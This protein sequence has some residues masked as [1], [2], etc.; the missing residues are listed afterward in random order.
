MKDHIADIKQNIFPPEWD[1]DILDKYWQV[2]DCKHITAEFVPYGYPV[3]SITEVQSSIINLKN[4]NYTTEL[5]FKQLID[6]GRKP[7]EGDLIL[8]RNATV[9]Q[10]ARVENSHPPFAMGQDVCLLRKRNSKY[11]S[12]FL[13]SLFKS[14]V[15]IKQLEDLMVGS[16]FKRINIRQVKHLI[17]PFPSEKE[18]AVIANALSDT[19]SLISGLEKLIA[20]KRNIK[21]GAIQ[22]LLN[23]KE[24]EIKALADVVDVL[25]NLRKPLNEAERNKMKGNIPYC[26]ANGIVD[27]VNDYII[28]DDI[29]LMAEDGGYFDE[30]ETRPIA[31]RIKG[32]CWVNN[33]AHILKT[34]EGFS[35]EFIFY[36]L[37]HKN[38]LDFINGGTRA[39]LNKGELLNIG[40]AIPKREDEQTRIATILLEMD[41]EL[42]ALELKLQKYRQIKVGMLQ[43]LL[44]GQIRLV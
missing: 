14:Q 20:K 19:D 4:A 41:T 2:I 16:T 32:K 37:V 12:K 26:G 22:K 17:I 34:K 42:D 8:S 15:I 31:Y 11:S 30:F 10:I 38:I 39:K 43:T 6:G 21:K 36:S 1:L 28:D 35:Q 25:D 24:K 13:Q 44:T 40:I 3:A 5:Y 27:Y 33:H 18:Q 9:G 23:S 7:T 29:I